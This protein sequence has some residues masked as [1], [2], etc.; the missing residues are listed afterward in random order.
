MRNRAK[1]KRCKDIIESFHYTDLVFCGCGAIG[2]DGGSA[3]KCIV[4]DWENFVRVDDEGNEIIPKIQ[5]A[6]LPSDKGAAVRKEKPTKK[7]LLEVLDEMVKSYESLPQAA[8]TQPITHYDL[9]SVLLL[10]SSLFRADNC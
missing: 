8:M 1:C 5:E 7:E 10:V 9:V 4:D 2:V 3:L 6:N